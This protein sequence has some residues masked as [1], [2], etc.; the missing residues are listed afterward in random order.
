MANKYVKTVWV[1][2]QEPAIN[3]ENLNKIEQGLYDAHNPEYS[4]S[5]DSQSQVTSLPSTAVKGEL[6]ANLNGNSVMNILPSTVS[7]CEATT[8]WSSSS[9]SVATDSSNKF[10]GTNCLKVTISGTGGTIYR[11]I[12][13]L[14]NTSKYYLV[15][16][17]V[18]NGNLGTGIKFGVEAVSDTYNTYVTASTSTSYLRQ[19]VVLQ[20]TDFDGATEV[21]LKIRGDGSDTQYGYFDAIMLQEITSAEYALGATALLDKYPFHNDLQHTN[22][23]RVKSVGKNLFDKSRVTRLKYIDSSGVLQTSASANASEFIKVSPSTNYRVSGLTQAAG[24]QHYF[25]WYD[26]NKT[27]ISGTLVSPGGAT[28]PNGTYTSPSNASYFRLSAYTVDLDATML[29]KGSTATTYEPYTETSAIVPVT[30]RSVSSTIKDTF[31]VNTGV[32]TKNVSDVVTLSG[33]A[34][35]WAFTSDYTGSKLFSSSALFT[36]GSNVSQSLLALKYNGMKLTVSTTNS[37]E[38]HIEVSTNVAYINAKDIDTGWDEIWVAGTTFTGLTWNG[39]IKAYMNGWKLT[40]ANTNVAS[41]VWTGIASGTVKN[42]GASDYTH[43]TTNIDAGF[44]QYRMIYQLATPVVTN[45]WSNVVT[46]EQS[47][48]V[49]IEPYIGDVGLY[50]SNI[51]IANTSYPIL[52][53]THVNKINVS[54]G[55]LTPVALSSCTV[56]SGGLTFTISG[57]ST[58]EYFE[59]GYNYNNLSTNGTL[60]YIYGTNLK[61]QVNGNTEQIKDLDVKVEK[62]IDTIDANK[63]QVAIDIQ[64]HADLTT[65]HTNV[66]TTRGDIIYRNNTSSARLAI[67]TIGKAVMSDGTDVGYGYPDSPAYQ[68]SDNVILTSNSEVTQTGTTYQS[69][70]T[71]RVKYSGTVRLKFEVKHPA[72]SDTTISLGNYYGGELAQTQI[73]STNSSTYVAKSVDVYVTAGQMYN[74]LIKNTGGTAYLKNLTVCADVSTGSV[75][76]SIS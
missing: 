37:L 50:G 11:N 10:E 73:S 12:L 1:D 44:Q 5:A 9:A 39:L 58:G 28:V 47:G 23:T 29:E 18:K 66:M 33:N 7:G 51:A 42:A 52:G 38:D 4:T 35:T 31:D 64:T 55:A 25:T 53:L 48:T 69:V 21:R 20:P 34:Y 45:Y 62:T 26:I 13:S 8:G 70:K 17:Y 19:G 22:M 56:A 2:E 68:S 63:T 57:A 41:C 72:A 15:S 76:N 3:A 71:F 59:Y 49:I 14:L 67:G 40:T 74:I 6:T 65:L 16:A 32:H 60:S 24:T 30:L 61:A 27:F 36:S 43:V 46:A 54:T 75:T